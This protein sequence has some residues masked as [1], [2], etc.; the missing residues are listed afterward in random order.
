MAPT[1]KNLQDS[2]LAQNPRRAIQKQLPNHSTHTEVFLPTQNPSL[3]SSHASYRSR[4]S[5]RSHR[6]CS[7]ALFRS[8]SPSAEPRPPSALTLSRPRL[9]TLPHSSTQTNPVSTMPLAI[10]QETRVWLHERGLGGYL[11]V[12]DAH[13]H[14]DAQVVAR[15]IH[16]D[17]ITNNMIRAT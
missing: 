16:P 7:Q 3:P 2:L 6:S 5:H 11:K 1:T 12:I 9:I 8:Q 17:T 14:P 15:C 10:S 13:A 4:R